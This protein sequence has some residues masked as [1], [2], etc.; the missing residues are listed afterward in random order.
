MGGPADQ[1]ERV[2]NI[3]SDQNTNI[4]MY[5]RKSVQ[6]ENAFLAPLKGR[7]IARVPLGSKD[8]RQPLL[9]KSQSSLNTLDR[10]S[11]PQLTKSN[12]V[13]GVTEGLKKYESRPEQLHVEQKAFFPE[14][15]GLNAFEGH[16]LIPKDNV[17]VDV[18]TQ[19]A[20][21]ISAENAVTTPLSTSVLQNAMLTPDSHDFSY[22]DSI[23]KP[24]IAPKPPL[25]TSLRDT[26]SS[27]TKQL[28]AVN[29]IDRDLQRS[30]VDPIKK[31]PVESRS[32][33]VP[34]DLIDDETSVETIPQRPRMKAPSDL[35]E[36]Y[37]IPG[38]HH[39]QSE[40]TGAME[41]ID[42]DDPRNFGFDETNEP[43]NIGMTVDELNDLL[44]M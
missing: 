39:Y 6:D 7:K 30:N 2:A 44:D 13:L 12:L 8:R 24:N 14:V 36:L 41:D 20:P 26:F 3:I 1:C 32:I 33:V 38:G 31:V 29:V 21:E 27:R 15:S 16:Q 10:P 25:A 22:T 17:P 18:L 37:E 19:V 42:L 43:E 4:T 11:K 40:V 23:P 9:Q 28:D 5:S 34:Q 35:D